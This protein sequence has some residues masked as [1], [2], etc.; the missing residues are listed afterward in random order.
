MYE[1]QTVSAGFDVSFETVVMSFTFLILV[2]DTLVM[3][4]PGSKEQKS[5]LLSTHHFVPDVQAF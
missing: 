4:V 3:L 1:L 2:D 5:K